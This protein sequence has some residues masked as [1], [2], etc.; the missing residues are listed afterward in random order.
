MRCVGMDRRRVGVTA[1]LRQIDGSPA[2]GSPQ[3]ATEMAAPTELR[4]PMG[5]CGES[6]KQS[7]DGSVATEALES[8]DT[9]G[10]EERGKRTMGGKAGARLTARMRLC[11]KHRQG[12]SPLR[13][14]AP[15]PSAPI[16][17]NGGNPSRVR[18]PRTN[19]APLTDSL[20]SEDLPDI[21]ERGP[22]G[23]GSRA[24]SSIDYGRRG[25]RA[26]RARM[27]LRLKHRQGASPLRPLLARKIV[28]DRGRPSHGSRDRKGAVSRLRGR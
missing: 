8:T 20:R 6:C 4:T 1:G 19:R 27:R 12:A 5:T 7:A 21:R 9:G 10:C 17:Q 18:K 25:Q 2:M 3:V 23:V 22:L 15:F 11:L 24:H 16:F 14:P 13:P 26:R 28:L